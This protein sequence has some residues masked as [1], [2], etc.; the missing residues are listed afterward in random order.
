VQQ[1]V[2]VAFAVLVVLTVRHFRWM[3]GPYRFVAVS[4]S[5]IPGMIAIL[6]TFSPKAPTVSGSALRWT[7][8]LLLIFAPLLDRYYSLILLTSPLLYAVGAFGH[9]PIEAIR[10]RWSPAAASGDGS[11][12]NV[13]PEQGGSARWVLVALIAAFA[14]G[15]TLYR[16]LMDHN[17]GHSAAMFLGIPAVMAILLALTPKAK[18]VTGG[19]LKG[20]TLALLMVAP[21]LGE[22]YVCIVFASPLFYLVGIAV[23]SVADWQKRKR[24]MMLSCAAL[25]LLPMSFEGIVPQLSFNRMQTVEVNSVVDGTEAT[26][27]QRLALSPDVARTLP[28]PLRIGFPR[29]M[30]AWGTG[31]NVG[32][33]RTIHFAGAEGDPPG[34][35]IMLVTESR[36]G[37]VRFDAVSDTS[38]LTQWVRWQSSEV[39]WQRIDE[40]HTRVTWRVRFERELDP[41]WYFAPIERAAVHEAAKY[42]IEANAG[43]GK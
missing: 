17:L 24:K 34:D 8:L 21:L 23:G 40:S 33:S 19:I 13:D 41:A 27:E 1:R 29:P 9:I 31:L 22:G 25:V 43:A 20:I 5:S 4:I 39:Q 36:A 26:V 12:K 32:A 15:G 35:L 18:T 6:L 28:A 37:F 2:L 30:D 7:V 3:P 10:R 14:V 16:L 42:L 38:K 11:L